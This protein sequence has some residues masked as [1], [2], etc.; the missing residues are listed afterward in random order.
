M[1]TNHFKKCLLKE[2]LVKHT[3]LT[4][5]CS[6]IFL[7]NGKF[8]NKTPQKLKFQRIQEI[9]LKRYECNRAIRLALAYEFYLLIKFYT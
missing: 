9:Y 3:V 5:I 1:I 4:Y 7:K 6:I 2:Q 8:K